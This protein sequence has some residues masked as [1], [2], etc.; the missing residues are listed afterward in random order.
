MDKS[1]GKGRQRQTRK[2]ESVLGYAQVHIDLSKQLQSA[3]I[4]KQPRQS[5]SKPAVNPKQPTKSSIYTRVMDRLLTLYTDPK[6]QIAP[7][8]LTPEPESPESPK[9][10]ERAF[11]TYSEQYSASR[12]SAVHNKSSTSRGRKVTE[13]SASVPKLPLADLL[14]VPEYVSL[15]R[16]NVLDRNKIWQSRRNLKL[17]ILRERQMSSGLEE[18]TFEPQFLTSR[19]AAQPQ[20]S[21]YTTRE[22]GEDRRSPTAPTA[23]SSKAIPV[24]QLSPYK[25]RISVTSPKALI[26]KIKQARK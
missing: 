20:F 4:R 1:K 21:S 18:C 23:T 22:E 12:Q 17:K 24:C 2:P 19:P 5:P 13:R 25:V 14:E 11:K 26:A 16:F 3:L 6:A 7:Q 9:T 15:Y 8:T 10:P